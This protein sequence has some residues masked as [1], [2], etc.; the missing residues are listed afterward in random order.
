[1]DLGTFEVVGEALRALVPA[2]LGAVHQRSHRYGIKVWFGPAKPPR[3]HYEAQV[4]GA[5]HV[6]S[7][8]TL[9]IEVGFHAEHPKVE[10]NDELVARLLRRESAW[11]RALGAE[12]EAGPFLGRPDDWRRVSETWPDPDLGDPELAME[13][14]TRLVDYVVAFEPLLRTG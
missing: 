9:A 1:V 8:T 12:V 7:A 3:A 2:E 11:R 6:A 10:D 4:V 14:A 5:R 13:V